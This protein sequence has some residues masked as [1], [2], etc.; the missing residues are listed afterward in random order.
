VQESPARI[1]L[2][3]IGIMGH[4]IA[5]RLL[6]EGHPLTVWNR[7]AS[8]L[9]DLEAGGARRAATPAE[10]VRDA[11]IIL[12]CLTDAAATE[13][14]VFGE[15]GIVHGV[16]PGAVVLDVATIP[17]DATRHFAARLRETNGSEWIDGP[18]SGGPGAARTGSLVMFCGGPTHALELIEP[19]VRSLTRSCTYMGASGAGQ[20][21][22]LC[23]QLIVSTTIL[24]IAEAIALAESA[25]LEAQRL[26]QVLAG[27]YADS[28]P[29]KIFGP[30]MATRQLEPRI[31][32][33]ATMRKDVKALLEMSAGLPV[34]LRLAKSVEE[35]YDLAV[36]H[37]LAH[38][39]LSV[40]PSLTKGISDQRAPGSAISCDYPAI[41][42]SCKPAEVREVDTSRL[43]KV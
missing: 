4:A 34:R 8:K 38:E 17:V 40:L 32:E 3:G 21:T 16:Q 30:R 41:S 12:S 1:A 28:L 6:E 15:R 7:T 11:R 22:K 24:A 10:A 27:G 18:V 43:P 9:Q 19:V 2:L 39:D 33:V 37:G 29:L 31:S 20:A 14:V 13:S 5:E 26:P 36:E 35:I 23:N 42:D 25:G